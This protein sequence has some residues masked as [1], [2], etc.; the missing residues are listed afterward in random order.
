MTHH[1]TNW[2]F[3]QF[4]LKSEDAI[5]ASEIGETNSLYAQVRRDIFKYH[6]SAGP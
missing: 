5:G 1:P 2:K 3:R 4:Y 6:Y